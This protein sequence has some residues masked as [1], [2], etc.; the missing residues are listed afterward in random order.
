MVLNFYLLCEYGQFDQA[1]SARFS[2]G[3]YV[4]GRIVLE[5]TV[6]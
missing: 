6:I 4:I 5:H 3:I 2:I 1:V